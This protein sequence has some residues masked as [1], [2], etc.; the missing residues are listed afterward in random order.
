M[1]IQDILKILEDFN[2]SLIFIKKAINYDKIIQEIKDIDESLSSEEVWKDPL[3]NKNLSKERS[4]LLNIHDK[5]QEFSNTIEDIKSL[6]EISNFVDDAEF[7]NQEMRQLKSK[8]SS[9]YS[10][11]ECLYLL[12]KEF[13]MN[14]C[15]IRISAGAG[16]NESCDWVEMLASMYVNWAKNKNM[17]VEELDFL[18]GDIAGYRY[19]VY[20]FSG[21]YAYGLMKMENGVHR[22]VRN[23][24]FDSQKRR[25]TSFAAVSVTPVVDIEKTKLNL[26][27][28]EIST[29]RSSGAGGQHLNTTDSKVRVKHIPT[30]ISFTCQK[31]RSQIKNKETALNMLA[32]KLATINKENAVKKIEDISGSKEDIAWGNHRRSYILSPYKLVKDLFSEAETSNVDAM[33]KGD[34]LDTFIKKSLLKEIRVD[35]KNK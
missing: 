2:R 1:E 14:N 16:G 24:P 28:V 10:E 9:I 12:N 27:E 30:G 22:L 11:M 5:V 32:S 29:S 26:S 34:L 25:H 33:L 21:N 35:C 4:R 8:A 6:H 19:I 17:S 3:K 18:D 31:E 13:D 7:I 15:Y 20:K 23:S